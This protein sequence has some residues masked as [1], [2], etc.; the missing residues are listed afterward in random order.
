[1]ANLEGWK[2]KLEWKK[3]GKGFTVTVTKHLN[4]ADENCWCVYLYVYPSH[5]SF[6]KFNKLG[7]M[8]GQPPFD[9]HS[10]VSYFQAHI[11]QSDGEVCSYQLGWDYNHD[12]DS[13]YLNIDRVEDAGS[14]FYDAERL[15]E[16]A[17]SW[18][19]EIE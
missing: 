18:F 10:Y 17:M 6:E 5:P 8:W 15:F 19:E 12:G 1:M 16:Q 14:I 11:R 2:P 7:T 9:C 3:D 4:Y 13:Y